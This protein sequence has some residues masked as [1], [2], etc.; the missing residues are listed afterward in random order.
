MNT[1]V[2]IVSPEPSGSHPDPIHASLGGL[3]LST[4][5]VE[6]E[7]RS[8]GSRQ[9]RGGW[10]AAPVVL[11][12]NTSP[13]GSFAWRCEPVEVL[14]PFRPQRCEAR[15]VALAVIADVEL[16]DP[17]RGVGCGDD[18]SAYADR[19]AQGDIVR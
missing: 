12:P 19:F 18:R 15:L 7:E 8:F 1:N 10:R 6:D 3:T 11:E 13:P 16:L 14:A 9:R 17:L 5:T 2:P 4:D